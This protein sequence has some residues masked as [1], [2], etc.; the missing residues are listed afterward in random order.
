MSPNWVLTIKDGGR[1]KYSHITFDGRHGK[2]F[3]TQRKKLASSFLSGFV[4]YLFPQR[5]SRMRRLPYQ[6][7]RL[8]HG[9]RTWV[10]HVRGDPSAGEAG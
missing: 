5:F 4:G 9:I 2:I 6:C 1:Y 8:T 7:P 3:K 10:S